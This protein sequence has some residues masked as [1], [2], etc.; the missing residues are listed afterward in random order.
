MNRSTASLPSASILKS[1]SMFFEAGKEQDALSTDSGFSSEQIFTTCYENPWTPRFP[2]TRR[3]RLNLNNRP[4]T[5]LKV[6]S[7][8][9]FGVEK[10]KAFPIFSDIPNDDAHMNGRS[11]HLAVTRS[12][13][14]DCDVRTSRV[15]PTP[16]RPMSLVVNPVVLEPME[17]SSR[18]ITSTTKTRDSSTVVRKTKP[19]SDDVSSMTSS[20][21]ESGSSDYPDQNSESEHQETPVKVVMRQKRGLPEEAEVKKSRRRSLPNV[22]GLKRNSLSGLSIFK[23]VFHISR[24]SSIDKEEQVA[25]SER[26]QSLPEHQIVEE[27]FRK[28]GS[29]KTR[30][31]SSASSASSTSSSSSFG[32]KFRSTERRKVFGKKR[33]DAPLTLKTARKESDGGVLCDPCSDD[34]TNDKVSY[35]WQNFV[36]VAM[37]LLLNRVCACYCLAVTSGYSREK[38]TAIKTI[39]YEKPNN[40]HNI[41]CCSVCIFDCRQYNKQYF[42]LA[43]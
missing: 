27:L 17:D 18:L 29:R 22:F 41:F 6:K 38:K 16:V 26:R 30:K 13:S 11:P 23:N 33:C 42:S 3:N 24:S 43:V 4:L 37:F 32:S 36:I 34:S 8:G 28:P 39:V 14:N 1:S 2:P 40:F 35:I 20:P 7:V 10:T 19:D 15:A 25:S 21:L 9:A 31:V 12:H 5:P